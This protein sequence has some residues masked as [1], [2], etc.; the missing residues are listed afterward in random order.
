MDNNTTMAKKI[1]ILC[2][3]LLFTMNNY[4]QDNKPIKWCNS[5]CDSID[6][7]VFKDR[8]Q[9]NE[10]YDGFILY[11]KNISIE[12]NK[13]YIIEITNGYGRVCTEILIFKEKN[14]RMCLV[15]KSESI[16]EAIYSH[17]SIKVDDEYK[18]II[19]HAKKTQKVKNK[20]GKTIVVAMPESPDV[21]IGELPFEVLLNMDSHSQ[22]LFTEKLHWEQKKEVVTELYESMQHLVNDTTPVLVKYNK[23]NFWEINLSDLFIRIFK[24]KKINK[25]LT[26]QKQIEQN[27]TRNYLD[28]NFVFVNDSV[29][30]F[31]FKNK[32]QITEWGKNLKFSPFMPF[33]SVFSAE[34]CIKDN[35]IYILM[36]NGYSGI[37]CISFYV[38]KE[39]GDRWEL[40]T[41]SQA[42]IKEQV[43]IRV[44]NDQ[45]KMIFEIPAGQIGELPFKILLQ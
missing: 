10:F 28:S 37:P 7:P 17:I 24:R 5:L 33:S 31:G 25:Q 18:K 29:V 26:L 11:E 12:E 42:I 2:L 32:S 1:S 34:F 27:E 16:C 4:S 8:E 13:F 6:M 43:K 30:G 40:Q 9:I 21:I 3:L 23:L 20:Q 19:F 44:D 39:K 36:V 38:F 14:E 41:T 22:P 45:E 35:N 15:S